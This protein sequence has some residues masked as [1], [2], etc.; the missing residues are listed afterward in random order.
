[1]EKSGIFVGH[2]V[3]DSGRDNGTARG[4]G[5][6]TVDSGQRDCPVWDNGTLD[7]P[8]C[9]GQR[10]LGTAGQWTGQ[11]GQKYCPYSRILRVT[12]ASF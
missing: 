1:M 7:G 6:W 12:L 10:R 5:Q 2:P 3:L 8:S 11:S 9:T 4:S